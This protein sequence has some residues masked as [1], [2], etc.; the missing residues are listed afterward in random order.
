VV[1]RGDLLVARRR[2]VDLDDAQSFPLGER[3]GQHV[4]ARRDDH[5]TSGE[6]E[7]PLLPVPVAEDRPD[8]VEHRLDRH[9]PLR[10]AGEHQVRGMA[11]Q[12]GPLQRQ[13]TPRL[14]E[15]PVEADE[16]AGAA[17]P[18]AAAQIAAR[19][20]E[21]GKPE[22]ARGEEVF[23]VPEEVNLAVE[24]PNPVRTGQH[25]AVVEPAVVDLAE[26]RGHV[27]TMPGRESREQA[28]ERPVARRFRAGFGLG[29]GGEA[30]PALAQLRQHEEVDLQRR[31]LLDQARR[32]AAVLFEAAEN[33]GEL[34]VSDLHAALLS[35]GGA[36]EPAVPGRPRRRAAAPPGPHR[37]TTRPGLAGPADT[38][39]RRCPP[40]S[41]SGT[42]GPS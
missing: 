17:G 28:G 24:P 42:L 12:V 22:I 19:Q 35:V 5:R 11:D 30:I 16:D 6:E 8:P 40:G 41:A 38:D 39:R 27:K 9:R 10:Q 33:G 2:R 23:L 26:A 4:A 37:D 20:V 18:V 31:R 13:H 15:L 21:D 34:R 1:S 14:G 25:G 29:G 32:G 36:G 3:L 7:I